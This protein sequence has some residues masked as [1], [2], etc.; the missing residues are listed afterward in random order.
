LGSF[1]PPKKVQ[2]KVEARRQSQEHPLNRVSDALAVAFTRTPEVQDYLTK[3]GEE[4]GAA[5]ESTESAP[6]EEVA[7]MPT[8]TPAD[9]LA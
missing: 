5:L 1:V 3:V 2:A 6:A 8:V 4:V 7:P 9:V